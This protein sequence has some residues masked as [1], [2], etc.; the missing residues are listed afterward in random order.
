M[1]INKEMIVFDF[2]IITHETIT[3]FGVKQVI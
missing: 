3:V 1:D 2:E